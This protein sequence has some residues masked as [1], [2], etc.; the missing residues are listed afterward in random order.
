MFHEQESDNK[1]SICTGTVTESRNQ[2]VLMSDSDQDPD[3]NIEMFIDNMKITPQQELEEEE[4]EL[5]G[6]TAIR[7]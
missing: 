6:T 7:T 3:L 4:V 2:S 1:F 5:W